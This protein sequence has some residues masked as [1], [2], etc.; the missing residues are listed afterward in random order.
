MKI[1]RRTLIVALAAA[2]GFGISTHTASA[3]PKL[4][5]QKVGK[6]MGGLTKLKDGKFAPHT[7]QKAPEYYLL[8]FSA[9]W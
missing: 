3:E 4:S 7:L 2:V 8:Y 9:S 6:M 1:S 5:D